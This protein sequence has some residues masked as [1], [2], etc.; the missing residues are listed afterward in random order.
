[1]IRIKKLRTNYEIRYDY[2]QTLTDYIKSLPKD[3][4]AT[5]VNAIQNPDG[6]VKNDWYRVLNEAGMEKV[7]V[8]IMDNGLQYAFDNMPMED[9]DRLTAA[10]Q[11]KRQA[12]TEALKAKT[13]PIDV[14]E[15]DFSFMKIQPYPY[16]KQAV[17][18]FEK[19]GGKGILGDQPGVGKTLSCIAF[20]I[21]NR[22]RTL[23]VTPASLKLN[24]RNEIDRFTN[25]KAYIYK[26]KPKR[27]SGE[28]CH[29]KEESLFHII[30]YESL[31]TF[32]KYTVHH[33]CYNG[34]CG[35][36]EESFTKKHKNCPKCKAKGT[37]KARAGGIS[38]F[39]DKKGNGLNPKDYDLIVCDEAHYL[40]NEQ[41]I[42]T[43]IIKKAF[44]EVPRKLLV[45]GTAIKS[46]PY[47]FFP[48]LNFLD[49]DE[50]K[51]AHSF[52]VKYCD[53]KQNKF[54]WDY[55]GASNLE[56]LYTRVSPFFLRRLKKDVLSFLPAKTYTDIPLDL[57]DVE[58]REYK[59][60]EEGTIAEMNPLD[61]D[62]THLAKIT[63]M[64]QFTSNAKMSRAIDFATNI[65]NG[66]EKIV[67]FSQ[68]VSIT[69]QIAAHFG[70]KA[71]CFTG[72]HS[73]G[74]KQA[75]V[76]RFM[77]DN[78]CMVFCGTLGAA[79][80]GITLTSASIALF[81]DQPWTPSDMEQAEDRI[82][83]ASTTSD[84][85]Q[86][87]KLLCHDTIDEEI[88]ILLREK[89]AVTSMVLDGEIVE[90]KT[91]TISANIFKDLIQLFI[92]RK[93]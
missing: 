33:K 72:K 38:L 30:N 88:D 70:A 56:E 27:K 87:I 1:M 11:A 59:K 5:K 54:G 65:I 22:L 61:D 80:V 78:T 26:Y 36:E 34:T 50:W 4:A 28:V 45:T 68:F 25:E 42:R 89:S 43:K 76:D 55:D 8:F 9:V 77:K 10:S 2:L 35:F 16:Q 20:A 67:I 17:M 48:L 29:T 64:R 66:G 74:E 69:E 46:R 90:K 79:G 52:G 40:K 81:V 23:V 7:M 15:V 84:K 82:H 14:T 39:E 24:W 92:S 32:I 18:F 51:N 44:K 12:V 31:E 85:V 63:K 57:S 49:P 13:Q 21:K 37:V 91:K 47:E 83:R 58:Y 86:I 3:Q 75:A 71:V 53:G 19:C 73:A 60:I 41:T 93:K 6:T 62:M